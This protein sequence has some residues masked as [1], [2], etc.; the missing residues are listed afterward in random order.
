MKE[1][2]TKKT[3]LYILL[4]LLLA[5]LTATAYAEEKRIAI[6]VF[7]VNS[8]E[9]L[10]YIQ[11]GLSSL[12]PPRVS[13]PGKITV[14]DNTSV[15][16]ALSPPKADYSLETKGRISRS[17]NVD[18]LLTGSLTKFGDAISIDAFLYD[19]ADP[20]SS[21]PFSV[22]CTGLDNLIAQVQTL[23]KDLQ[24]R[25]L[26][27]T[28]PDQPIPSAPAAAQNPAI[29]SAEPAAPGPQPSAPP[30][31]MLPMTTPQPVVS[32]TP[33]SAVFASEPYREYII[34]HKPFAFMAVADVTGQGTASLLLCDQKD[35]LVYN[36]TPEE[37][38]LTGTIR[39]KTEEV[40]AQIATF[41]LNGNGRSEIYVSS[42]TLEDPNTFIAEY[43]EGE[44]QRIAEQMPW[45]FSTYPDRDGSMI[46][47]GLKL[48]NF[49]PFTGTSYEFIWKNDKP[50]PAAEYPLPSGVSPFSS[51][52]YDLNGDQR[53]EYIA[54]SKGILSIDYKLHV[55]TNTG[56]VLWRDSEGFGGAPH[57][58]ER[59]L[60]GDNTVT[61][62]VIPL[63]PYCS[64]IDGD[65]RA[66][67]LLP[68]NTKKT[69]GLLSAMKTYNK[70]ELAGLYW[71]GRGLT[72][73]WTSGVMDGY[74]SDFLVADIDGDAKQELILLTVSF[75]RIVGKARNTIRIY[76]QAR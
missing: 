68:R 62:E 47:L 73:N 26:Y 56:R 76:K 69:S 74:V 3:L 10:G 14:V 20:E 50:T 38:V 30:R 11:S 45:F 24:R 17:I 60:V 43:T 31:A 32:L 6:S 58:F 61:Q 34:M 59:I 52:H 51:S 48:G 22:S 7:Q 53:E 5:A 67:I 75:P 72:K 66:D 35:V 1:T 15:R 57:S 64:D 55:L 19:A 36:P 49:N 23:A 39:T 40:I 18:Y 2:M 4:S 13:L 28:S 8:K 25:I 12:L 21:S 33:A 29:L 46:L 42:H 27:G 65:S 37:L 54:F 63:R 71:D 41:D 16:K 9:D 44:Y 70:G